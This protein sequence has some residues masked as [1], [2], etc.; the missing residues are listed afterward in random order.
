MGA[1]GALKRKIAKN[2][3]QPPSEEQ[4]MEEQGANIGSMATQ[5]SD[6]EQ[7]GD[8]D[9]GQMRQL[10][11]LTAM[12]LTLIHGEDTR[13]SIMKTLE[14]QPN[15]ADAVSATANMLFT[16]V[17]AQ[18][19]KKNTKIPNE[20]KVAAAQYVVIDLVN[21]GNTAQIWEQE[22]PENEVPGIF[23]KVLQ[24]YMRAGLKNK[25]IDPIQLQKDIEQ[26]MT[27]EQ[28][29][30]GMQFA[31]QAGEQIPPGP[32]PGMAVEQR[33]SQKVDAEKAKTFQAQQQVK[34]LKG[35][36]RQPAPQGGGQDAQQ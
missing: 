6:P 20:M 29:E 21:L 25:S 14:S 30:Q 16:R 13:D 32:T 7:V 17:D 3:V 31:Q 33:V 1:S 5:M 26:L 18:A 19:K 35:A 8:V 28:K 10:E 23:G 4:G 27:D 24:D 9:P 22:V 15:P 11:D 12:Y 34:A 2:Q 36:M